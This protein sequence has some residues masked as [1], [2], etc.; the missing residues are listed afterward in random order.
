M[1]IISFVTGGRGFIGS[2][3]VGELL[4][5]GDMVR[6]TTR[7]PSARG[8]DQIRLLQGAARRLDVISADL[9]DE[10][11]L[12]A[13][14]TGAEVVFH[15]ASPAGIDVADTDRDLIRPAVEGTRVVLRAAARTPSIR[16][17]VLTS[18]IAAMT[19]EPENGRV[20]S[21]A[22]W[23]TRSS[24]TRNAYH[25]SK[26]RAEKAAWNFM[27]DTEPSFDLVVINP[28][29]VIGP[30]I[31]PDL[32]ASTA[33][34]RDLINGVYPAVLSLRFACVDVR[35]V[36]RAH[37]QAAAV[38]AARGRYIVTAETL[39]AREIVDLIR[40]IA[41]PGARLP[42]LKLDNPMGDALVRIAS[43]F[44][45]AGLAQYLRTHIGRVPAF[46]TARTRA[47]LDMAFRDVRRSVADT[48]LDFQR[49]GHVAP[50]RMASRP[51]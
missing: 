11:A 31:V 19:D 45:P 22:D 50:S 27:S 43:R 17:V 29:F 26:A 32:S 47:D 42:R 44:Q 25:Y 49:W 21:E 15:T 30:S 36:A 4:S 23:N 10:D 2:A 38:A 1:T 40:P 33:V 37:V 12:S 41:G 9:L 8:L 7:F 6:T 35:D 20:Y 39:S 48:V 28:G 51:D 34:L 46:D 14:M 18:S 5:R 3:L 24:P 13:A 16:R